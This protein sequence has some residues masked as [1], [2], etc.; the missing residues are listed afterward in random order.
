MQVL[1]A[2]PVGFEFMLAAV[3]AHQPGAELVAQVAERLVAETG[4]VQYRVPESL[5]Q[6]VHGK[7][8]LL[9]DDVIN[10]GSAVLAT[11]ADLLDCGAELAGVATLL[12]LGEA[13]SQIAEQH[14]APLF[15]LASLEREMR[16]AEECPLCK[17]GEPLG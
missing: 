8:V 9:V 3:S 11:L 6:V 16:T 10:A 7:R 5:R 13:A 14:D 17:S 4:K 12:T 15:T 2:E 1:G